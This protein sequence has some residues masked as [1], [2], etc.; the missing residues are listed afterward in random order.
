M[1]NRLIQKV[2]CFGYM[3]GS[4]GSVVDNR[5]VQKAVS[6]LTGWFNRQ[7]VANSLVQKEFCCLTGWFRRKRGG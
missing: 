1:A 2:E 7:C 3:I 4:A 5:L 6:W